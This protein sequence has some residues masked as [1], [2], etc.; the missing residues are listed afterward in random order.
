MYRAILTLESGRVIESKDLSEFDLNEF[1]VLVMMPPGRGD[2]VV[3]RAE[4]ARSHAAYDVHARLG[5][6]GAGMSTQQPKWRYVANL[7]DV[8]PVDYGGQFLFVDQT[9]V[10]DPELEILESPDRDDAPEGW[11]VYRVILDRCHEVWDE[12]SDAHYVG[13]NK[14]HPDHGA[15]FGSAQDL[16]SVA[17]SMDIEVAELR[18][19]LCSAD[20]KERAHGYLALIGYYGAHEFDQYP[21]QFTKRSEVNKRYRNVFRTEKRRKGKA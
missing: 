16:K 9:G 7:G 21:L 19:L 8:N 6:V 14:F 12:E 4:I 13:D 5:P 18:R 20:P 11:T 10:Y 3:T 15:W 17:S 1:M 2:M